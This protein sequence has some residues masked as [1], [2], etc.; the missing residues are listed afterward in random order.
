M[1]LKAFCS[2]GL[3]SQAQASNFKTQTYGNQLEACQEHVQSAE[4]CGPGGCLWLPFVDERIGQP[5]CSAVFGV[6]MIK[7]TDISRP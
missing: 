2:K 7:S 6:Q 3:K 5:E 4:H 1:E